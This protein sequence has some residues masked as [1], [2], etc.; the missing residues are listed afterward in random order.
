MMAQGNQP[1][2][3]WEKLLSRLSDLGPDEFD[4][5]WRRGQRLIH[6]NG[7]T[8]TIY[9][10]E[11]DVD[12][13]WQLDPV[14]LLISSDEWKLIEAAALQRA[15]L[16]NLILADLYGP[17]RLLH[18]RLL[19][20][21]AVFAQPSLV[22][23]MLGVA[24]PGNIYNHLHAID[25]ARSPDGQ[26]WVIGDRTQAPSGMGY[27]LENR[28][29]L[30]RTLPDVVADCR[31]TRLAEFFGHLNQ[32]LL[33]LAPQH[34]ENPRVVLMTPGPY[35][36]TYFEHA[37]LAQYLG[38]TLAEGRDLT[39]RDARVYL[40]TLSGLLPVDVIL[41]RTD[42][43]YCDPLELRE[44]SVLGIAG[45]M[46]AVRAGTVAV[47]N[48]LGSGLAQAPALLPFLPAVC[49]ELLGE[50]LKLPTIATWW[51]GQPGPMKQVLSRLEKLVIKPAL[52][53]ASEPI[54]G[55]TLTSEQKEELSSR[56]RASPR[57]WI[58]QEQVNLSTAPSWETE[59]S[60]GKLVPRHMMLRIFVAARG[61]GSYTVMPGG[62]SR[63]S[64]SAESMVVSMQRG[65]GSKD[66]WV[67]SDGP[68]NQA[69]PLRP[70]GAPVEITR[71]GQVLPSRVAD[72]MFWLGR[73]VERVEYGMRIARSIARRAETDTDG[74][75]ALVLLFLG[76]TGADRA[77]YFEHYFINPLFDPPAAGKRKEVRLRC[78]RSDIDQAHRIAANLRDR[79]PAD[80]WRA[81]ARLDELFVRPRVGSALILHLANEV[82]DRALLLVSAFSGQIEGSMSRDKGWAFLDTGRRIERALHLTE[83]VGWAF[84]GKLQRDVKAHPESGEQLDEILEI[85]CS[86]RT[87]RSR[88]LTTLQPAPVLDLLM[89]DE[90]NPQSLA[91]QLVSTMKHL[92]FF[93]IEQ[94]SNHFIGDDRRI[95]LN[96]LTK[97]RLLE[98]DGLF[99]QPGTT[100]SSDA[101]GELLAEL[102]VELPRL[103]DVLSRLYLSHVRVTHQSAGPAIVSTSSLTSSVTP[104]LTASVT[105]SATPSA[106]PAPNI[107]A[108][109]EA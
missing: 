27:A 85:A 28:S 8:Y 100:S 77:D 80:A 82:L 97:V 64:G 9:G 55:S 30:N 25:L 5:R 59:T 16:T 7:V 11:S 29:V 102:N 22:R 95:L 51:C 65:G 13:Q 33:S 31:V 1:R 73:Y 62:L 70:P 19:P 54:F 61:D 14:P 107:S 104:G 37:Y 53:G 72:E 103:S 41:R 26:W 42:D 18:E 47:A 75:K 90:G 36:E 20:A 40:K 109:G 24:V 58:A 88:Y 76:K 12:R 15:Q 67:L 69:N 71:A 86:M 81:I 78:V 21:A 38:F 50:S 99:P 66:T 105:P 49:R 68:V 94:I 23:P 79:L 48:A 96:L 56:I 101:L 52:P 74:A 44:D 35:N 34:R 10:D 83:L 63:I 6:E 87:Y 108:G 2:P 3:Y 60:G 89:L 106:T 45:L 17:Q 93:P 4:K 39:V 57:D 46:Q 43:V 98:V 84:K 92:E 91:F 32:T